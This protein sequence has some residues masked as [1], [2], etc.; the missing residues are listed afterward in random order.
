LY[1]YFHWLPQLGLLPLP[2]QLGLLPLPPLLGHS[3]QRLSVVV[4]F[5]P[6]Q[7]LLPFPMPPFS[8]S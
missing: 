6:Q 7:L 4:S 3:W 1:L 2:P 8:F 5:L